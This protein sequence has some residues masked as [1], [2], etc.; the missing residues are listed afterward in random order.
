M[1]RKYR[2]SNDELI[3]N[4]RETVFKGNII[5]AS[6][7]L[8]NM[9]SPSRRDDLISLAYLLLYMIYGELPFIREENAPVYGTI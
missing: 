3:P 6:V 1:V 4:K 9:K 5:F 8:F 2:D 7:H